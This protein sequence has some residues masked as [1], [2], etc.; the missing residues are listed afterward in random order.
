MRQ[1]SETH[2]LYVQSRHMILTITNVEHL[3]LYRILEIYVVLE[4]YLT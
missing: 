4:L 1:H 3:E 2:F